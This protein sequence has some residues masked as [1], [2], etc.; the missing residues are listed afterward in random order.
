M[1]LMRYDFSELP[2]T[3]VYVTVG[4]DFSF[5]VYEIRI[6]TYGVS[7]AFAFL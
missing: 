6:V 3:E 7:L 4:E 5:L 2:S 1:R